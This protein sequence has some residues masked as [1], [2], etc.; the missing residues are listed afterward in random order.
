MAHK[1]Q[2]M[3]AFICIAPDGDESLPAFMD[4]ETRVHLPLCGSDRARIESLRGIADIISFQTGQTLRLV[5]FTNRRELEVIT[6][7]GAKERLARRAGRG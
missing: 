2:K 6:P 1:M 7:E 3:Y 4:T 5:E